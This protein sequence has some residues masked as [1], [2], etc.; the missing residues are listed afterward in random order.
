MKNI[1]LSPH[2]FSPLQYAEDTPGGR[3]RLFGGRILQRRHG[4]Q[5]NAVRMGLWLRVD[6]SHS[7]VQKILH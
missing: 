2:A 4:Y 5:N 7:K 1:P 3:A 6:D